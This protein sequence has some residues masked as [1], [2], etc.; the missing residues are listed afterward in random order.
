MTSPQSPEAS[1]APARADRSLPLWSR[2]LR[3]L[4]EAGGLTQEGWAT[5]LEVSRSTVQRWERG[6]AAP[7][8]AV[9]RVIVALC[10]ERGLFRALDR[11]ALDGEG[12]SPER[13]QDLLADAR[14][15]LR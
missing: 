15:A 10:Q 4:R 3:A 5:Y 11:R 2:V 8:L 12:M 13:L 7:D 14:V 6:E 1:R 9:E